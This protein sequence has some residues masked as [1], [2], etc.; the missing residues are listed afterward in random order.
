VK[1]DPAVWKVIDRQLDIA[2]KVGVL[3]KR[4][5]RPIY[6]AVPLDIV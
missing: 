5:A 2:I 3:D 1:W 4:P 6:D